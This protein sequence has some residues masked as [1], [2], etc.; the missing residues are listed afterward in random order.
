MSAADDRP[1]L[2][3]LRHLTRAALIG[4][5]FLELFA[6]HE[7][8]FAQGRQARSSPV[9]EL[10]LR[11]LGLPADARAVVEGAR[12]DESLEV[13]VRWNAYAGDEP[14]VRPGA[15]PPWTG[16]A[17]V[18]T[19]VKE[20]PE[21]VIQGRAEGLSPDQLVVA[22]VNA[23]GQLLGRATVTDPRIVRA[24][25]SGPGG[26]LRGEVLHRTR[27]EFVIVLP[28]NPE[29]TELRFYRLVR[30]GEEFDL[31]LIDVAPFSSRSR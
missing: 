27:S 15:A 21:P 12:T 16:P 29:I 11:A 5:V 8:T 25:Q 14:V 9:D 19:A 6:P 1:G 28:H 23:R 22:A 2:L 4:F 17:F 31:Q 13:R 18:I 26:A 24:E 7:G 10:L 30:L 20:V 3:V